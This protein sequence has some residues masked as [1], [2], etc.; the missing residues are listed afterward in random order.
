MQNTIKII[1]RLVLVIIQN[2]HKKTLSR[3][4]TIERQKC[5][6]LHLLSFVF[7][8]LFLSV[9]AQD[10]IVP[11]SDI[12]EKTS[13]QFQEFFFNAL[14][15]K[16]IGNYHL[17]IED[18]NECNSLS[19][20]NKAVLFELSKN[21][22]FLHK[23]PEAI[24]YGNK[25]LEIAPENLWILEH[26]VKAYKQNYNFN[27]AIKIQKKIAL[28]HP[29]KKQQLVFLYLLNKNKTEAQKTLNELAKAKMLTPRLRKIKASLERS[30]ITQKA[31]KQK[32]VSKKENDLKVVFKN[33][34]S[35]KNLQ[36]LLTDLEAKKDNDLLK[37]SEEGMT[38]FPAQPLVYLM[39]GKALNNQK[40]YK[41]AIESLQNGIDFVIDDAKMENLFFT[42]LVKAYKALGD[43]KNIEKYRKKIKQ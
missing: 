11:Q 36:N 21:F 26:L 15:Q 8:L 40:K 29:K 10:S 13:L 6:S 18:L 43:K 25:A 32:A 30:N 28:L 31:A 33:K 27:E 16:A 17:A 39:N 19:P 34:K 38:I 5:F 4:L 14:T 35:F 22:L 41:K 12:T 9:N 42:E 7:C 24:E 1:P 23:I 2:L 3:K 37:Y 20:K